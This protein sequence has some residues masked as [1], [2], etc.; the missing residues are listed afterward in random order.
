[1]IVSNIFAIFV[2]VVSAIINF[3][4][5]VSYKV[6]YLPPSFGFK[7]GGTIR[8]SGGICAESYGYESKDDFESVTFCSNAPSVIF[9]KIRAVGD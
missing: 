6:R 2:L 7:P 8:S 9:Y 3:V 5:L 4:G 1:M